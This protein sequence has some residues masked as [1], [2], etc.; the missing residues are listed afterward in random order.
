MKQEFLLDIDADRQL[1]IGM[2]FHYCVKG[3][4]YAFVF[5]DKI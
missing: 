1:S 3:T 5:D 4:E 2:F